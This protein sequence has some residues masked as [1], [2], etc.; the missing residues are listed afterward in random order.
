MHI[1]HITPDRRKKIIPLEKKEIILGNG[2][3]TLY[4]EDGKYKILAKCLINVNNHMFVQ[5]EEVKHNMVIP[6]ESGDTYI[7]EDD[8]VLAAW[9]EKVREIEDLET[10]EERCQK[11]WR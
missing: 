8:E 1:I 6:C 3:A 7:F 10:V 2:A 5:V 11:E 9:E 4:F